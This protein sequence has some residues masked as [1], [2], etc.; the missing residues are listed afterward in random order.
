MHVNTWAM[1]AIH[2]MAWFYK[3][4]FKEKYQESKANNSK[5]FSKTLRHIPKNPIFFLLE[6]KTNC[7]SLIISLNFK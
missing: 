4:G 1:H 7:K 6:Y 3:F 5:K 2:F